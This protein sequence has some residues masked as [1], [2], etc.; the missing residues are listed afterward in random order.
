[1][2][3]FA[4]TP[5]KNPIA[6][7]R[8]AYYLRDVANLHYFAALKPY[9][10]YFRQQGIHQNFLVV[11]QPSVDGEGSQEYA[12]YTHLFTTNCDLDTYDLVLTPT[13]LRAPERT[14]HTRAIQI[15]H[16]MSDKPF[17]YERDFS[18]YR[19]C[20]CVGQRQVDR[21]LQTPI[22]RTMQWALVGYPKF[23][24]PPTLPRLF[25]NDRK[26][27]IYC[28]TWRK[29]GISS[30][31]RFLNNLD[32]VDQIRQDYNLIVKPHPNIF[33]PN[34]PFYDPAIVAQ[35]QQIPG[36][37]LIRSGNVMP[38]FAQA[39][40]FIGDISA[41]GYEWLYFARPAV[42]LNPQPGVLR[43]SAD[44]ASMTYLWQC[45][46]VCDQMLELKSLIDQNLQCDRYP[47]QREQ[48]L[49]YSVLNPRDNRATQRG[50]VQIEN[51]LCSQV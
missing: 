38:W 39:D 5:I 25:D 37:K 27:I 36:I 33:N 19:L 45:G 8:I 41:A 43:R 44:V 28:P 15:F 12:G 16:G 14:R 30:I 35:L 32:V 26:T 49:H 2:L 20:L 3:G 42:F 21:L 47:D 50:I 46:D 17:T 22:N 24:H 10:D 31:E 1:M 34:R 6:S 40:L 18:D 23:D 29:Q 11:R 9:L 13:F 7:Q 4:T 48:V 51:V